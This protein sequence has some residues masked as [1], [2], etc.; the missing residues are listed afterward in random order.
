MFGSFLVD[1]I[2][3]I[4]KEAVYG[5]LPLRIQVRPGLV[6]NNEIVLR[7]GTKQKADRWL[8]DNSIELE[9]LEKQ[10]ADSAV[11]A[12]G[13]VKHINR[14]RWALVNM[15]VYAELLVFIA[16][17]GMDMSTTTK[18][19]RERFKYKP[20]GQTYQVREYKER[21]QG[22]VFFEIF[23]D[24]KPMFERH[25]AFVNHF[26]PD[27]EWLFPTRCKDGSIRPQWD[28]KKIRALV[29]SYGIPWI[30]PQ[31]LKNTRVN[32]LLRR[33]GDEDRTA[34]LDQHTKK[35]LRQTY[36]QPS[37][38]RSISEVTRFWNKF[39]PIQKGDLKAS[40]IVGQCNGSPEA[41]DDKPSSV[42]EPNCINPSGCLW[43][44]R[45]RDIDS[46]DYVWSLFS[47]RYLKGLEASMTIKPEEIPADVVINR[48]TKKIDWYRDNR[49]EWVEEAEVRVGEGYYH[50]NWANL[51]EFLE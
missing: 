44:K 1:L 8:S 4:S 2:N 35:V 26:Y 7:A 15:R 18:L 19:R 45:S 49:L 21:R 28:Q 39:D 38:Q 20:V 16:Q 40:V 50:P 24:Y 6:V 51:I 32:Y 33:S 13:T 36:E 48:L 17:T 47:F 29:L 12:R 3:G 42:V 30:P 46:N 41:V 22:E 37:Q 31:L 27:S 14:Y 9:A 25:I 11:K 23:K 10:Y 43:C 5:A 34:E